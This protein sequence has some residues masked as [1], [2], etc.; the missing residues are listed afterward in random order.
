MTLM[1]FAIGIIAVLALVGLHL[2]ALFA[3]L[4]P[5]ISPEY[6][7][8]YVDRVTTDWHVQYYR[9]TPEDGIDFTRAGWPDFVK[10]S[11]GIS[12]R[13]TFGRWT[14]TRLG[15]TSGFEFNRVFSGPL[16]VAISAK[17]SDSMRSRP[18]TLAFGDQKR[19]ITLG[20][21]NDIRNYAIDFQLPSPSNRLEIIFPGRLP[22]ASRTDP[23]QAGVGLNRIR[24]FSQ[25]CSDISKLG[26]NNP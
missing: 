11:F 1:R 25:S 19:D 18:V 2:A 7:A 9:S 8:F 23:R 22:R 24:I 16:C 14:D 21:D 5:K 13:D 3:L 12:T 20:K 6:K 26:V 10:K 15:L 4:H 17:P